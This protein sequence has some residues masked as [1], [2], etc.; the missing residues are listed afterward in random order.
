MPKKVLYTKIKACRVK[1]AYE[2]NNEKMINMNDPMNELMKGY[3]HQRKSQSEENTPKK[4][5]IP[6]WLVVDTIPF[7]KAYLVLL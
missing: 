5:P 1:S 7:I 4:R 6:Q 3:H 2:K